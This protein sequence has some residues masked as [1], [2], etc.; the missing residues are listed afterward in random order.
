MILIRLWVDVGDQ[1]KGYETLEKMQLGLKK[2]EDKVRVHARRG[3]NTVIHC[4]VWLQTGVS[5]VLHCSLPY[6][7]KRE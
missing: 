7:I 2:L 5:N 3:E 1:S 6:K 4:N